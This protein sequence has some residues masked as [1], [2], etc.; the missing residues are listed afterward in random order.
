[1]SV[2][3]FYGEEDYNIE[4]EVE[5]LKKGLDKNFLEMS[6]KTYDNPKFPDL[7]SILRS[8]P[9][10][11][12]KMLIVINCLDYFSKT[13]EDK[14]IKEIENA[15]ENNN[16]NL[17]I[18]FVAQLPRNEGKKLDSR[19]KLFKLLKKFNSLE[20]ALIPT[21]KTAELESWIIKQGKSKGI[22][23]DKDA[24]TAIISQIGNNLRQIDGELDK[25][26][27]FAYPNDTINADMVKE[28]CI[29]NEDLFAFSDFLME[30]QKDRAL[31]E[32]RKLLDTRYPLEILSTLQ[33]MLRR[34]IILKAKAHNSTP[35]ELAKLTGMHE[36]VVKLNLQKLKNTNLKDLVKLKE[37]LT[38]AE[39]RIKSGLA[40]DIEKEVEN[41]L[42]RS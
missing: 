38:D 29:S 16:D 31:L 14:E 13:F 32:Y 7:I 11:F 4:Q 42:F 12:G 37:N 18:V 28:I 3:F 30:N 20:C 15:L 22:K 8:Q 5:K 26:K 35:F 23:F 33:T 39:Y 25:L 2:Y 24:L 19:K 41:A 40:L 21:Y 36:Y 9:M 10:M 17:D 34:W 6:F 27:L 1:M